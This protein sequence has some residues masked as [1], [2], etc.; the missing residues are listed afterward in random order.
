MAARRSTL[1]VFDSPI[2]LA[3]RVTQISQ[4]AEA[5]AQR[6]R[7]ARLLRDFERVL[8]DLERAIV[9]GREDRNGE[10]GVQRQRL[11]PQVWR[12]L[13]QFERKCRVPIGAVQQSAVSLHLTDEHVQCR[14]HARLTKLGGGG[15]GSRQERSRR[16]RA[17]AL[18]HHEHQEQVGP[19]K[20]FQ[21]SDLVRDQRGLLE[22]LDCEVDRAFLSA[23][24]SRGCTRIVRATEGWRCGK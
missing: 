1:E 20:R 4:V 7:S 12:L 5:G 8:A 19:V 15:A 16:F 11:D 22:S 10:P 2:E 14:S 21:V 6:S 3:D 9:I 24:S 17:G 23:R 18:R 13:N